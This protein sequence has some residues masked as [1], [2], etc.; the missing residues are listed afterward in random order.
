MRYVYKPYAE[1]LEQRRQ[2]AIDVMFAIAIGIAGAVI[3]F[4]TL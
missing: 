2:A 1:R 4:Y 3:L